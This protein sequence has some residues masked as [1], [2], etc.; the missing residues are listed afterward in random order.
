MTHRYVLNKFGDA[1][2]VTGRRAATLYYF[3]LVLLIA[4]PVFLTVYIVW[5]PH[6][7]HVAAPP[8]IATWLVALA[9]QFLLRHGMLFAAGHLLSLAMTMILL[10]AQG[11]KVSGEYAT[12]YSSFIHL[13]PVPVLVMGFF[14]RKQF[15][16]PLAIF[17]SLCNGAFFFL[18]REKLEGDLLIAGQVGFMASLI[19]LVLVTVLLF[20]LRTIMDNALQ[21]V[22]SS[23][24]AMLRFVPME[25]LRFLKKDSIDDVRLGESTERE[26]TILFSDIRDFSAISESLTPAE[27]FTFINQYLSVMG[28]TIREHG[29]FID[30]Y[31]GDAI[32]GLF[33]TADGAL[34]AAQAMYLRLKPFNDSLASAS[35]DPLSIG[36]GIHTGRIMLGTIGESMRLENTV[37]SDAV[38]T[39]SRIEQ[40]NKKYLTQIL[41][42]KT[43]LDKLEK[44]PLHRLVDLTLLRGRKE[45]MEIHEILPANTNVEAD[46]RLIYRGQFILA[47][48]A[49]R[50][51]DFRDAKQGFEEY[52]ANAPTDYVA[53]FHLQTALRHLGLDH[54]TLT[55]YE[56]YGRRQ[57]IE[58]IVATFY[59]KIV[60]DAVVGDFFRSVNM[61]RLRKHQTRFI[62][63]V[64]GAKIPYDFDLLRVAHA[65]LPITMQHFTVVAGL[66]KQ[67]LEEYSV[68][69]KDIETIIE[70]VAQFARVIVNK[71]GPG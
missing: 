28:P 66:L 34:A 12:A 11:R 25:F 23:R 48:Q 30:K 8:M 69:A 44:K 16:I 62:A 26:M 19:S 50:A 20:L 60:S 15:I 65:K 51:G 33:E 5:L 64:M 32:M 39:T 56:K 41:I 10:L 43:A 36:I 29:G 31:I 17:L 22:E 57:T 45:V 68:E 4:L 54:S 7:L 63:V 61:N 59:E 13:F 49:L 55:L 6:R 71:K 1:D 40:L 27:N 53:K 18:I 52:L 21:K 42:S 9:G 58:K 14:G 46:D 3:N 2:Y 70:K 24:K 38:N 35:M 47:L 37:I 67:T